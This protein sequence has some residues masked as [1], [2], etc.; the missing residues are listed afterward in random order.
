V[1]LIISQKAQIYAKSQKIFT[2]KISP[3]NS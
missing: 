3:R 2:T 1:D